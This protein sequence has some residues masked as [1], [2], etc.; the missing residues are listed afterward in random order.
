MLYVRLDLSRKRLDWQALD[1]AGER[2][3]VGA[4]PPESATSTASPHPAK[5]VG[6]TGLCPRVEQSGER[7]RRGA[8]RKNGPRTCAGR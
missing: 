1:V 7:D 3:S 8:L 2:V 4:V 6:Y 5:R